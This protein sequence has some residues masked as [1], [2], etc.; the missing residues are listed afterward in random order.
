M[1]TFSLAPVTSCTC[2]FIVSGDVIVPSVPLKLT[3]RIEL[4][5]LLANE[6]AK[7]LAA[8]LFQAGQPELS[9]DDFLDSCRRQLIEIHMRLTQ[10]DSQGALVDRKFLLPIADS[11]VKRPGNFGDFRCQRGLAFP[12]KT[13]RNIERFSRP[14]FP[15]NLKKHRCSGDQDVSRPASLVLLSC[16]QIGQ[17]SSR[18]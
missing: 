17:R 15:S 8:V 18:D 10:D 4:T 2:D 14:V 7:L 12:D 6:V 3:R 5:I 16:E 13:A 11:L 1:E 9:A